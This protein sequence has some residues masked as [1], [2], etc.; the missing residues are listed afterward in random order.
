MLVA[1]PLGVE[2]GWKVRKQA[3]YGRTASLQSRHHSKHVFCVVRWEG[4]APTGDVP[5][6][7]IG[8]SQ[9]P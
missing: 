5:R 9:L 7:N 8:T 2:R 4:P 1:I 6:P 3:S